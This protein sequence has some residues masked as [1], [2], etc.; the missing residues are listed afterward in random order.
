MNAASD[1]SSE[2]VSVGTRQQMKLLTAFCLPIW[3]P[4]TAMLRLPRSSAGAVRVTARRRARWPSRWT[5]AVV[6]RAVFVAGMV[7]GSPASPPAIVVAGL[8]DSEG[9]LSLAARLHK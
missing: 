5:T 6:R 2:G 4:R 9:N 3:M 7:P 8:E 1:M